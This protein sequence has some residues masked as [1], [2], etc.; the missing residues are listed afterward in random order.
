MVGLRERNNA[1]Q[2]IEVCL[3]TPRVTGYRAGMS[4]TSLI[5]RRLARVYEVGAD[6]PRDISALLRDLNG[7]G[8]EPR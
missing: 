8:G 3:E 2:T 7:K 5:G 1:I 6:V 4:S